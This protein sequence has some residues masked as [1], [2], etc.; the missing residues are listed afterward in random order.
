M[1]NEKTRA[2][3]LVFIMVYIVAFLFLAAMGVS[4]EV[5]DFF[6]GFVVVL[7]LLVA[8]IKFAFWILGKK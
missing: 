1:K 3:C 5:F 2:F 4:I 8:I 6:H 7:G